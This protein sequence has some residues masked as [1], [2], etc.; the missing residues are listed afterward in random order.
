MSAKPRILISAG[1]TSMD[2]GAIF[3]DLREADLN[4]KIAKKVLEQLQKV[5]DIE[6]QAVPLDLPLFQ[7]IEWI[8][9]TG[10]TKE[11]NDILV[12]IHVNDADGTKRG[13]EAWYEGNGGNRSQKLAA[14]LVHHLAGEFKWESHGAKSEFDHELGM[15][16]FLNR[17]KP[18]AAIIEILY[19]D[20]LDDQKILRDDEQLDKVAAGTAAAILKY[21]GKDSEGKDLPDAEK[22]NFDDILKQQVKSEPTKDEKKRSL[23]D[24]PEAA[25]ATGGSFFGNT[26]DDNEDEN[27]FGFGGDSLFGGQSGSTFGRGG[28]G[29][30]NSGATGAG[31]RTAPFGSSLSGL[32][33]GG[34]TLGGGIGGGGNND[35]GSTMMDREQRKKMIEENYVK[36][37]GRKPKQS[38]L[39]YFLNRGTSES[40]LIKKMIDS[41]EHVDLVKSKKELEELKEK[42]DKLE[43]EVEKMRAGMRDMKGILD[44]LNRLILHKNHAITQLEAL[45]TKEKG[46][47]SAVHQMELAQP[48]AD[49]TPLKDIGEQLDFAVKPLEKFYQQIIKRFS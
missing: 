41:Q 49:K 21:F 18:A 23:F 30:A 34:S 48:D 42:H 26:D 25:S 12:E 33:K 19:L 40:E 29:L 36:I 43:V 31:G 44:N 6:V 22:P 13:L 28:R 14:T 47:P 20:N 24:L 8:N 38:D 3:Q 32:T 5:S 16:T 37:L 17:S 1:H 4:R 35:S 45:V 7:R 9:N 46:V 11:D 15:L 39:N 2:P 27:D 10:Y